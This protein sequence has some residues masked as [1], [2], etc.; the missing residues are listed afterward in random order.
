MGT[1]AA[2]AGKLVAKATRSARWGPDLCSQITDTVT[3]WMGGSFVLVWRIDESRNRED[4]LYGR[5]NPSPTDSVHDDS[6]ALFCSNLQYHRH[7]QRPPLRLA[8]DVALQVRPDFLLDHA[9]VGF[10][11][12][13]GGVEGFHHNLAG[14][15]DHAVFAER[16]ATGHNLGRGFDE[17]GEFVDGNDRH[18]EAVFAEMAAVFDD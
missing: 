16:K 1:T 4:N 5:Q 9:I 12:G 3:D 15:F 18:D 2:Y 6:S 7:D 11:F 17:S 13:A 8:R 10:L 14:A